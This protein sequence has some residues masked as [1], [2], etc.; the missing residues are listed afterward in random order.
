MLKFTLII[1]IGSLSLLSVS[2]KDTEDTSNE[3]KQI[4]ALQSQIHQLK[5]ERDKIEA[6]CNQ[7]IKRLKQ[8]EKTRELAEIAEQQRIQ[9]DA[10][11]LQALY[12]KRLN[13]IKQRQQILWNSYINKHFEIFTT[14][15][16]KTY[17]NVIIS[18]IK[19]TGIGF[20]HESGTAR[21]PFSDIDYALRKKLVINTEREIKQLKL[22]IEK[23]K[24]LRQNI[25]IQ[26]KSA[27]RK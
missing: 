5:Q 24:A 18:N 17:H 26:A 13:D 2:C 10:A 20:I 25:R 15:S 1:L 16:G 8:L 14:R 7:S 22:N 12:K 27:F 6:L 21:I 4:H 19:S 11:E 9:A 3:N 23:E